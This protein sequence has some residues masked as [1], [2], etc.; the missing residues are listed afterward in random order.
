MLCEEADGTKLMGH[1][2]KDMKSLLMSQKEAHLGINEKSSM[3][4][5]NPR[6]MAV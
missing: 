5:A 6:K 1:M 3:K 2:R 4:L